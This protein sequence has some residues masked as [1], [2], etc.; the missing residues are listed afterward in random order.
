MKI[1]FRNE[2]IIPGIITWI[3]VTTCSFKE[4]I[5]L[6]ESLPSKHTGIEFAN[7]LYEDENLN[8]L[9]FEYFYNGAGVGIGDINNDGLQ[10]IFFS[11][12]MVSNRLYLN[13][14]NFQFEDITKSSGLRMLGKWA[15]GI[16]MI[17]INLDGWLDLYVCYAGP[18]ANPRQ[19]ANELYINNGNNTFTEEAVA[20]GLA[21][22]GHSVQAA[23]FDYD[24]DNDLDVYIL[25]NTTDETGPNVIRPKRVSGEMIN[26][27][28]L[29][30]NN[31]DNTFSDVSNQAGITI[32]GY[33]LGVSI[34]DINTDG[35]PDIFVS[36]DYL[37]NDLLYVNNKD[38]KFT[39]VADGI[40]KHT[41]YS[42]M[43][44]DVS[45]FNNDGLVDII[46][47]DM[48]PPDN[49]RRKLMLGATNYDRYRSE[50]RYGYAPQFMRNTLQLNRGMDDQ[51][52]PCFS[53]IGQLSG[54]HATDW[55]WSPLFAD[56]DNDGWKDVLITNGYPR[57]ITNRDF[58]SYKAQEFI[59]EGYNESVKRKLLKAI[60]SLEGAHLPNYIFRNN[61]DLTFS[62]H[63]K[64]WGFSRPSYSTGSAYADLDNDGDL[65][66]V[67]SNTNAPAFIFKNH[68]GERL[69]NHFLRISLE[70]QPQ[71]PGG[72]GS[73]IFLFVD[74]DTIQYVEQ[75]P[76]RGFQSSVD[77]RLHVG[78]GKFSKIDSLL[79][80]WPDQRY[81][82]LKDVTGDREITLLWSNA[83]GVSLLSLPNRKLTGKIFDPDA[84]GHRNIR[85]LH[86]ETEYADFKIEPLVPHKYSQ[87]GPGVAVGDVNGDDAE[88]FFVGGAFKQSGRFFIQQKDGRFSSKVLTHQT[89][90]EE[91]MG[92]LLFDADN[93]SDNDL[94]VVSGGNEFETGSNYYRHR[95]YSNDGKGNFALNKTALPQKSFSGSCVIAADIDR[96]NDL[97]LFVG[98]RLTP[99]GYP[100]AGQSNIW[101]NE[102][103]VFTDVTDQIAPGLKNIGMVTAGL[104]TDVNNDG[105][106]DLMV[107]GEW[108]PIT[109]FLNT[110]GKLVR[111]PDAVPHSSGWWNSITGCDF[112]RDGDTDYMLGNLGLN[113]NYKASRDEPVSIYVS[114][115]NKDGVDDPIL[116]HFIQGVN[117]PAHPRDDILIQ[118]APFK[119]KY[120]SYASYAET[121]LEKLLEGAKPSVMRSQT[122][123][124]SYLENKGDGRLELRVLPVE[125]QVAPVYGIVA[126][127]FTG[128]EFDDIVLVGNFY[129]PEVLSGRYDAFSGLMLKGDGNGN[130][131][132]MSMQQSGVFVP[133]DAKG[134]ARLETQ[135]HKILLLAA[136]N[137]DSL[138]VLESK[139][140]RTQ[141]LNAKSTD[142][143]AVV[144][145]KDGKK[146][147]CEF[148]Y[149]SG[150]LSQSSRSMRLP[151]DA[152]SVLIFDFMGKSRTF[153]QK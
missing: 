25:T 114:D 5:S 56:I 145:G 142:F 15:T 63:S 139:I 104:W 107:V 101:R 144:E 112:D 120:P 9:T 19:R 40:F 32:E 81:Q 70:G 96:D 58:A 42:A 49:K 78:L 7:Q 23:F 108:M 97:D 146:T 151:I 100:S 133:G 14:G 33:G 153:P 29:Y 111:Q 147:K 105:H 35:W 121:T 98:G 67:I 115:L 113:S 95:L 125:A 71:N 11:G 27:D 130:F 110:K 80:V 45:D 31:G 64:K 20:Y 18:F 77:Q 129:S 127:E 13:K 79:I 138:K 62:D 143:Y 48:L 46:E 37:S 93:D 137:N 135:D 43:G 119:K 74:Q 109:L 68:A 94:Y 89:K 16:A 65:D 72:Y 57:D 99:H 12:N 41:S 82:T 51:G 50:L 28:K 10:D 86:S 134:L 91:D 83:K 38:G 2:S 136:Q 75:S 132:P 44:N 54:L 4:E 92:V 118:V 106:A 124:T 26:T 30:R 88:D 150:Y 117:R 66:Y 126:G 140:K 6:L 131:K 69:K 36:N 103:G 84:G 34:C 76:S 3:L 85:F 152:K 24:R 17:D 39:N 47:V 52:N 59:H 55:S 73:K 148:Y 141:V 122:F 61:G 116:A 8:I 87:N 22:T 1:T 53:E 60:G 102:N 128:D 123:T 90:Y 149:G 21:D